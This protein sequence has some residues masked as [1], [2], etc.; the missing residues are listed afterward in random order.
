[1][2]N[3]WKCSTENPMWGQ[4][5]PQRWKTNTEPEGCPHNQHQGAV[6]CT[7]IAYSIKLVPGWNLWCPFTTEWT[8]NIMPKLSTIYQY[9][10]YFAKKK[11]LCFIY[12]SIKNVNDT[13]REKGITKMDS[14]NLLQWQNVSLICSTPLC[15]LF[16]PPN[17][18]PF[19]SENK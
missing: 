1:M 3:S 6:N 10:I 2:R 14:K 7:Q 5:Q 4:W 19:P 9:N 11:G 18:L 13:S 8:F 17:P 16:T 12:Q 15:S